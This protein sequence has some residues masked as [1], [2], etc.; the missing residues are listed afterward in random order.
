MM[1]E[2][3]DP[4]G[5]QTLLLEEH[6]DERSLFAYMTRIFGKSIKSGM[7]IQILEWLMDGIDLPK[8]INGDI[9]NDSIVELYEWLRCEKFV[10]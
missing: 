3:T 1:S 5:I 7:A 2:I 9:N 8:F 6:E 4:F 10:I